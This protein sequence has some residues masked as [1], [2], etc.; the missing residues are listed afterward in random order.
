MK[1][2]VIVYTNNEF[3]NLFLCLKSLIH[4]TINDYEVIIVNNSNQDLILKIITN[5]VN[6]FKGNVTVING[7]NSGIYE[8]FN[9]GIRIATGE[10]I[11]LLSSSDTLEK[12][13]LEIMYKKAK[14]QDVDC[15]ITNGYKKYSLFRRKT[16]FSIDNRK[17]YIYELF[18]FENKLFKRSVLLDNEFLSEL[19]FAYLSNIPYIM[20][21]NTKRID[22]YLYN[23]RISIG[24]VLNEFTSYKATILDIIKVLEYLRPKINEREFKNI[25]IIQVLFRLENLFYS[26]NRNYRLKETLI[27]YLYSIDNYWTDYE[28]I[29]IYAKNNWFFRFFLHHAHL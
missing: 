26:H 12:D 6:K 20:S 11:K 17:S 15:L 28:I 21:L 10:Y 1:I 24:K 14:S 5:F 27:D 13:A 8:S 19:E 3:I 18:Y 23:K 29:K 7:N 4:Q 25:A 2:S 16:S 9:K 22:D